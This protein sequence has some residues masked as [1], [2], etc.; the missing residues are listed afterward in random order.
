[1][2]NFKRIVILA[3]PLCL[4]LPVA[5]CKYDFSR[6]AEDVGTASTAVF[7]VDEAEEMKI[8]NAAA[9]TLLGAGPLVQDA[10]LQRYVNR[11]G[12]WVAQHSSRPDLNW[13]FAVIDHPNINAFA[14]PGGY[15]FITR[16]LLL[17]LRSESELAGV[18]GHEIAHV[19]RKHHLD[20]LQSEARMRLVGRAAETHLAGKGVDM[21]DYAWV[22]NGAKA[23]YTNGLDR[24][25]ELDA[26]RIGVVLAARAG[27]DPYGLPAVLQTLDS[28]SGSDDGRMALLFKTHPRPA[29]RL[30][31]LG[32]RMGSRLDYLTTTRDGE[33]RFRRVVATSL[34]S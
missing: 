21:G 7:G 5:G 16:G 2:M 17:Q 11:V 12:R 24:D 10:E 3:L 23:L 28:F 1:M 33:E 18:L 27:Y 25:D 13:R 26:D 9:A 30:D 34:G 32:R 20:A 6:I 31:V 8:G 14:A 22:V 4:A 29:D 15:V 19:T